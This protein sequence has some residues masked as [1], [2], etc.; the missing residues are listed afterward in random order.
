[1]TEIRVRRAKEEDITAVLELNQI[2]VPMV[3]SIDRTWLLKYLSETKLFGIAEI[4]KIFAGYIIGMSPDADYKSENFLWFRQKY[5]DFLYVDR[6]AVG[7]EFQGR[8]VG[9]ELYKYAESLVDDRPGLI[10]C[11]VN[12]R[13]ANDRSYQFHQGLGFI[14]V[15]QQ[16]TKGGEIR[17]AMLAKSL[18]KR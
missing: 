13:P 7:L 9:K 16:E 17:V 2:N 4:G 18:T 10:T 5:Q 11:E 3:S 6:L 8:G 12:I 15:G 14:E 1:M